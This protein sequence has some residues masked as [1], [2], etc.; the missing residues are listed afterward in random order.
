MRR[1]R[2]WKNPSASGPKTPVVSI[3]T[4]MKWWLVASS[5]YLT[6]FFHSAWSATAPASV[7][8]NHKWDG[9]NVSVQVASHTS[10]STKQECRQLQSQLSHTEL[11]NEG[12]SGPPAQQHYMYTLITIQNSKASQHCMTMHL[13]TTSCTLQFE[14][15]QHLNCGGTEH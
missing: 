11:Q 10:G 1:P 7:A 13:N 8:A 9:A 5:V 3:A 2:S 15:Q 4:G 12:Q 6:L 14:T